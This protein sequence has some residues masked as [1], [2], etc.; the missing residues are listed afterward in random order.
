MPCRRR[1]PSGT[2]RSGADFIWPAVT[3]F[4][5]GVAY[6]CR[7]KHFGVMG[8]DDITHA[9]QS[10]VRHLY[11][12]SFEQLVVPGLPG[13]MLANQLQEFASDVGTV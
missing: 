7:V 5:G 2:C 12:R 3:C 13:E 9:L 10:A 4:C 11:I 8:G 1:I 6:W